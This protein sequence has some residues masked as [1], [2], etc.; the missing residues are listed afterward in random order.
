MRAGANQA[1]VGSPA[2][3]HE[4]SNVSGFYYRSLG[5]ESD[6]QQKDDLFG[7]L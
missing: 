3:Q 2:G 6:P 1:Q 5:G 4:N 7:G